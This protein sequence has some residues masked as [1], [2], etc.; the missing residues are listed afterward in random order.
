MKITKNLY[1]VLFLFVLSLGAML[2]LFH[3]GF[4]PIHD[5][6]QVQRVYEMAKALS[7]GMFPVRWSQDLG[8]GYGYPFFNFYSPLIYYISSILYLG[9][10]SAI[11]SVKVVVGLGILMSGLGM[12]L[13]VKKIFNNYAGLVAGLLYV[14]APYHA[15]DIY[16]RG[17]MAESFAYA[18]IPF[19]F[20]FLIELYKTHKWRFVVFSALSY[21]ALILTHNL[22][23]LMVTPIIL[24]AAVLLIFQ[25]FSKQDHKTAFYLILVILTS[26]LIAA[27]YWLPSL[28]EMNLTNVK[29]DTL[30]GSDYHTQFVCISQ[31][32]DSPWGFG[33]SI[34][35]CIDG[36]S[37]RVGK[38]HLV[39]GL[40]SFV[41]FMYLL[42]KRIK[43]KKYIF[44]MSSLFI[45]LV[46]SL[47]MTLSWSEWLWNLLPFMKFFQF[48]WRFLILASFFSSVIGGSCIFMLEK[49]LNKYFKL[50][51]V[52]YL[53]I[54]AVLILGGILYPKLFNP[55]TYYNV[56]DQN[57][58]NESYLIWQSSL[59]SYEY[60]PQIISIPKSRKEALSYHP[61]SAE[62]Q[63]L[64][65]IYK[66]T[67]TSMQATIESSNTQLINI[68]IAPFPNW[69]VYIDGKNIPYTS[70]SK[71][72]LI[73]VPSGLH[74][75]D[76]SYTQT[77]IEIW[78]DILSICGII[79]LFA[80]I[81]FISL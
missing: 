59:V 26:I 44:L 63:I 54:G 18:L 50:L 81:I 58:I 24:I 7:D 29:S 10:L 16:V 38:L 37:F 12:Y 56:T 43:L 67:T 2:P 15:L 20:Y 34:P 78:S 53:F 74:M 35:G 76:A 57:Y 21:S 47:Y 31:L 80:G 69:K 64:L 65:K 32:W 11:V 17:D 28:A 14:Y 73:S 77:P 40:L 39:L 5:N 33:G 68:H 8:F 42:F 4:F 61:V 46:F 19:I 52:D 55:Q 71:G 1:S 75:L 45:G 6:G 51:K 49:I 25:S 48:P 60:L 41:I 3:Q 66:Q 72:M 30:G 62:S 13:L 22:T 36:L 79:I 27:F 70:T 23:A 9:G